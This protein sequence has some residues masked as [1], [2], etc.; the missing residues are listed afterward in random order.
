MKKK[1]KTITRRGI[2]CKRDAILGE[3]C[4]IHFDMM[5]KK[6]KKKNEIKNK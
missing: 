2:R 6:F 4:L 1:C 3:Y 5:Q